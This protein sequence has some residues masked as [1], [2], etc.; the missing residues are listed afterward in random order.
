[1]SE[2]EHLYKG[3]GKRRAIQAN[4]YTIQDWLT[5]MRA[6]YDS[7]TGEKPFD[8][9]SAT[10]MRFRTQL[11][12]LEASSRRFE[13][14]L[15]DI[16]QLAQADLFDSELDA[17]RELAKH[18]FIRAAGAIAGVVL[19]KHLGQ[20]TRNHNIS[21]RKQ[22]PTISDL[23]DA[24]KNG[25]VID[26]PTWRGIQ[27]LGDLRNLCDHNKNRDPKPDEIDELVEGTEKY[28]KTLF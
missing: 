8:D 19:E 1:M 28:L 13:S 5:G 2:F 15:F 11:N 22:H 6:V 3:D 12:I 24:L 10:A 7:I 17:A 9:L 14:S 4:S 20:V 27:R 18:G 26:T 16:R 21:V 23:N 25:D